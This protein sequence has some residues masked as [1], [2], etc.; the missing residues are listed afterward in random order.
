MNKTI[1]IIGVVSFLASC[2]NNTNSKNIELTPK[3]E[4]ETLP[5]KSLPYL[6]IDESKL[7]SF[8]KSENENNVQIAFN[9]YQRAVKYMYQDSDYK[10]HY[11]VKDGKD[12]NICPFLQDFLCGI[13]YMNNQAIEIAMKNDPDFKTNFK[14]IGKFKADN[15]QNRKLGSFDRVI[16]IVETYRKMKDN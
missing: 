9:A 16:E 6:K 15:L 1:L 12:I 4:F 13:N 7:K 8:T 2:N 5:E 14:P 3:V 10:I 11:T